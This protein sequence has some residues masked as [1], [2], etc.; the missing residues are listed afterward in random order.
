M[1]IGR[2][3]YYELATGNVIV[4]TGERQGDVIDTTEDQDFQLYTALQPFQKSAVG[5]LQLTF[6]QDSQNFGKYPYHVDTTTQTIVWDTAISVG[7]TLADVQNI[8]KVQLNDL[9]QQTLSQGFNVT[10]GTQQYTFGWTTDDK[11]NMNAV[12]TALDKGFATFPLTYADVKGNPVTIPDQTTLNTIEAT[13]S[14]FAFAQHQQILNL[15]GQVNSATTNDV[16]NAV[17][18]TAAAY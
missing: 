18:W 10:I 8:K 7:A 11:A 13:A 16:V 15:F 2:K 9:Y 6:G 12:Q 14:K 1:E 17:Q 5:V 3:I 4:D